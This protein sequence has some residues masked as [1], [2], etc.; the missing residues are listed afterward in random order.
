M[1]S[2]WPMRGGMLRCG[3]VVIVPFPFEPPCRPGVGI[4]LGILPW[5]LAWGLDTAQDDWTL[6]SRH[7]GGLLPASCW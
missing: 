1:G 2:M 3:P 4:W 5:G 7:A 6:E